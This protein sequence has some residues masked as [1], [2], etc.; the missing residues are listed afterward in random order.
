MKVFVC[1]ELNSGCT[2][3]MI[4]KSED[5]LLESVALHLRADHRWLDVTPEHVA[6]IRRLFRDHVI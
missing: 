1:D 2:W 6:K 4:S 3:A 5:L